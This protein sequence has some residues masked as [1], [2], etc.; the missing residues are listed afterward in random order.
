LPTNRLERV[1]DIIARY[2]VDDLE[3]ETV[4]AVTGAGIMHLT[5]GLAKEARL[6]VIFPHHEQTSSMA[7]DAFSR[8][9][10]KVGVSFY[11][12]GPAAT[13]ALTGLAGCWQDSVATIFISGQVK[14]SESTEFREMNSV[15]Q[16]GVQELN[17]LPIIKS[18][19]KY[20]SQLRDP[21]LILYE[22]D[23]AKFT[24]TSGRP[25]PVWLEIPMDVQSSLVETS[26]LKRFT[27]PAVTRDLPL[28]VASLQKLINESKRPVVVAGQGIR[29][30]GAH[31][32]FLTWVEHA[33][34]PFVTPYLGVDISPKSHSNYI[35]VTGV[36]GD[37]ASNWAMQSSDLL[38]VMG[39]SMHV[40]VTGYD[41]QKFAPDAK[42]ILINIDNE[43]GAQGNV[44][45]DFKLI[46]DVKPVIEELLGFEARPLEPHRA[47]TDRLK[48]TSLKY[49][50][51]G[52]EYDA[53]LGSNIYQIVGMINDLLVPNDCVISDAGSAFYCVSQAVALNHNTQRYITSGA[54]AT[55]GFS[56]PAAIGAAA[57]GANRVFA[58]TGD[59]S[60]QQTL[61]EISLMALHRLNIKLLVLN[62]NGYLSIRASQQNYFDGRLFGTD[63]KSGVLFPDLAK[64]AAAYGV[65]YYK[66]DSPCDFSEAAALVAAHGPLLIEIK[67]PP[68]QPIIPTVGSTLSLDGVLS[69]SGIDQMNPQ[70]PSAEHDSIMRFL[71]GS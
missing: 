62:N 2:M 9:S 14:R 18:I 67:C 71:K 22:L 11:S 27:P 32:D 15:R 48:S 37:R 50:V 69:S 47:W 34:I 41:Y 20:A 1:A 13:N 5:D 63:A 35:G 64:I 23:K 25:G 66:V 3:L 29:L 55:M 40:S 24:A 4:F 16:F 8:Y 56:L 65:N 17:I 54:M 60:L 52:H 26:R 51:I 58:Y 33:G 68:D 36:K 39:S 46:S 44:H 45:Y 61:Q 12:T 49:P 57:A 10:G 53:S 70:M 19:T 31:K 38:I 6:K 43:A 7:V 30:S 42:K 59:G 28:D 21:E